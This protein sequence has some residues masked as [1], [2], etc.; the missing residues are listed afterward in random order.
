MLYQQAKQRYIN[1]VS[2]FILDKE[3][4]YVDLFKGGVT[5]AFLTEPV[6]VKSKIYAIVLVKKL[7]WACILPA[8]LSIEF[9]R[10]KTK[11]SA[12]FNSLLIDKKRGE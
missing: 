6:L 8:R 4:I 1:K 12:K 10:I 2:D 5:P 11:N 3:T 9:S 7:D